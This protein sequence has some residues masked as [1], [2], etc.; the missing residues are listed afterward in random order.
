M[1]DLLMM[2]VCLSF[3]LVASGLLS[4]GCVFYFDVNTVYPVFH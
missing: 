1:V 2:D 3:F 4:G